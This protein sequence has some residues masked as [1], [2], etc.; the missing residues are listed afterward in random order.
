[1]HVQFRY[2]YSSS[3]KIIA[4]HCTLQFDMWPQI[5]L[6]V[7]VQPIPVFL[8]KVVQSVNSAYGRT[9]WVYNVVGVPVS[10]LLVCPPAETYEKISTLESE[11][12]RLK[13]Q[14]AIYALSETEGMDDVP[15]GWPTG[16]FGTN[17]QIVESLWAPIIHCVYMYMYM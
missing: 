1:M 5:K 4:N 14:I 17:H 2:S 15:A 7:V 9:S 8:S 12:A 3:C 16:G 10:Q 6:S 11:L 13:A